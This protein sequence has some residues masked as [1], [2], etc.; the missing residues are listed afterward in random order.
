M[1]TKEN[2]I[3]RTDGRTTTYLNGNIYLNDTSES[4]F[5]Y[6]PHPDNIRVGKGGAQTLAQYIANEFT[7]NTS[8][9]TAV[10]FIANSAKWADAAGTANSATTSRYVEWEIGE[11]NVSRRIPFAWGDAVETTDARIRMVYDDNF[12]YNPSTKVLTVGSITGSAKK[13][14]TST[15]GS[16]T[17][18]IYLSNGEPK[19]CSL[20]IPDT[21]VFALKT[22][23]DDYVLS[24]DLPNM[25]LYVLKI[26]YDTLVARVQELENKVETLENNNSSGGDDSTSD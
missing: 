6:F 23:L 11:S 17:E 22:D 2:W 21:S 19:K 7:S 26:D 4:G 20:N 10:N 18:P 8:G 3:G 25:N 13:L 24:S 15:V 5:I 12:L 1:Y 14:G 16:S 9:D